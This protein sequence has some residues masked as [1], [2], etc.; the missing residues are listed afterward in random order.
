MTELLKDEDNNMTEINFKKP[1][2]S[3]ELLFTSSKYFLTFSS[4]LLLN[5]VLLCYLIIKFVPC[6]FNL[7]E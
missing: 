3:I 2:E 7:G 6:E 1:I 5:E 4:L